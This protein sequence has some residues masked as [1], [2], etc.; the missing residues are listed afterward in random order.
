VN[1]GTQELL[2]HVR[3]ELRRLEDVHD[4]RERL[5]ARARLRMPWKS[6]RV[7]GVSRCVVA[8]FRGLI[9]N[10]NWNYAKETKQT[11]IFAVYPFP[12]FNFFN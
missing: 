1:Q 11:K 3:D 6:A 10:G 7:R 5:R 12:T 4:W 9:W 8:P 2:F